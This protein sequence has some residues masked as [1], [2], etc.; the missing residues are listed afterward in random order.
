MFLEALVA[1]TVVA[2]TS[3]VGALF[4][5]NSRHLT[6]LQK[7]T[8]PVA[9]GVFLSLVLLELLPETLA[10]SPTYGALAVAFGFIA[11]Y[12]LA[13]ILHTHY[14]AKNI[15]NCDQKSAATL[16]LIGDAVHNLAD[17]IILGGAFLI[18]PALGVA[19]AVGLALHEIPQEIVEFGVLIRAGFSR[20]KALAY[21]LASASTIII[22]TVLTVSLADYGEQYLFILTGIA[23]GNLLFLATSDLL[24]RIHGN[25]KNYG[26]IWNTAIS[27]TLGFLVMSS[28]LIWSHEEFGHGHTHE[29][30]HDSH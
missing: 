5:G 25:L 27:I 20:V 6:G 1:A 3:V 10:L 26:G 8:I 9:V 4:F 30:H 12:V 19:T 28:V 22:G 21:N 14:H 13:S 11:F 18:D 24:P 23:A 16:L 15:E 7:Y 17:G 29:E 2:L